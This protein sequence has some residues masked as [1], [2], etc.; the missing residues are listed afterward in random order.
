[1]ARDGLQR[2]LRSSALAGLLLGSLSGCWPS[3]QESFHRNWEADR[4]RRIDGMRSATAEQAR[5]APVDGPELIALLEDTTHESVFERGPGGAPGPY[6]ERSYFARGG[7]FVYTNS[8]WARDPAG[9]EG[10]RWSVEGPRLCILS[11]WFSE[12]PQCYT[13][14]LRPDGRIQYFVD[15]PERETHGLLTSVPTAVHRGRLPPPGTRD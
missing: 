14:A 8:H 12:T 3:D 15:D 6:V 11:Q 1:M 9:R 2:S 7:G 5:G 10:D 4:A 13:I